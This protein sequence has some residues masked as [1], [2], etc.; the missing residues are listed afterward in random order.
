MAQEASKCAVEDNP[1]PLLHPPWSPTLE[2]GGQ[3]VPA[4]DLVTG[5]PGWLG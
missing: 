5:N 4:E 2:D 3:V 1:F